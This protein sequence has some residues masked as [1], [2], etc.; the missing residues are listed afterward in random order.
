MKKMKTRG[1]LIGLFALLV[2]L[3]LIS[4]LALPAMAVGNVIGAGRWTILTYVKPSDLYPSPF[5]VKPLPAGGVYFDFLNSQDRAMLLADSPSFNNLTGKTIYAKIAIEASGDV[6]FQC[7]PYDVPNNNVRFYFQKTDTSDCNP[8]LYFPPVGQCI[9]KYWWSDL[10]IDLKELADRQG[11]I[12]EVEVPLEAAYWSDGN[13]SGLD[14]LDSFK[15]SVADVNGVGLSF[16]S[17]EF[18]LFGCRINNGTARFK[19]YDFRIK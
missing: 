11:Q 5:K 15:D 13:A 14:S 12:I 2:S 19:L 10:V 1:M 16:G 6:T 7:W 3:G 17:E 18:F 4:A 8:F 9:G